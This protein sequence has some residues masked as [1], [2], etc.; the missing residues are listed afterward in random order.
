MGGGPA[1]GSLLLYG[2]LRKQVQDLGGKVEKKWEGGEGI[3]TLLVN[4]FCELINLKI[5]AGV[6]NRQADIPKESYGE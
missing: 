6:R 3:R 5:I 1:W 2:L 4:I